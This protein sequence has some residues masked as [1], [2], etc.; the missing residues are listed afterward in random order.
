M[1]SKEYI[2][3]IA[4]DPNIF[5]NWPTA[6][7]E[8]WIG[9]FPGTEENSACFF[10]GVDDSANKK[11]I[12]LLDLPD[13]YCPAKMNVWT[14]EDDKNIMLVY[15]IWVQPE[16]RRRGVA[17]FLLVAA[18]TWLAETKGVKL[19]AQQTNLNSESSATLQ[20]VQNRYNVS[21]KEVFYYKS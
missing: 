3:G 14:P 5:N 16:W 20:A 4:I 17:S 10:V 13:V 18:R 1:M 21:D 6:L 8:T 7:E 9:F 11:I 15:G 19:M 12:E 2:D